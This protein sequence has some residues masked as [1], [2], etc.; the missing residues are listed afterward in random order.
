M[1]K[2]TNVV[3]GTSDIHKSSDKFSGD[4]KFASVLVESCSFNQL[5]KHSIPKHVFPQVY[6]HATK[7]KT[8]QEL[9]NN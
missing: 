9:E 2:D 6:G 3:L 5:Q 8:K 4:V 1:E 7:K